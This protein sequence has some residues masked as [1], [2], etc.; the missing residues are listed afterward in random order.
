MPETPPLRYVHLPAPRRLDRC[1]TWK[2]VR[3]RAAT[4][5]RQLVYVARPAREE[6]RCGEWTPEGDAT[7][8]W[9]VIYPVGLI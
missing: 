3:R 9:M 5:G 1:R 2:Q 6:L 8:E 4:T 7:S